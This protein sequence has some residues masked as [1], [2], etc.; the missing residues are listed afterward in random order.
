MIHKKHRKVEVCY[1]LQTNACFLTEIK[2]T[3]RM[4]ARDVFRLP[5]QLVT[6]LGLVFL[7]AMLI[8]K[9][10]KDGIHYLLAVYH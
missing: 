10:H 6:I 7:L 2:T 3:T 9:H 1:I 4:F 8:E 5:N